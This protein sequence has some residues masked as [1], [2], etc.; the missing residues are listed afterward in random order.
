VSWVLIPIALIAIG[1]RQWRALQPTDRLLVSGLGA[2]LL[3]F[4][5]HGVVDYFME[6]T[7]TYGLF[8]LI[9]GLYSLSY[10]V[11]LIPI[12]INGFGLQELSVTYLF[13]HVGSLSAAWLARVLIR[14]FLCQSSGR[15][16][17]LCAAISG[18]KNSCTWTESH[19]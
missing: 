2:A 6:F 19:N 16:F 14:M 15:C 13:L 5:L 10:L 4:F 11:T 17:S 1:R 7:P 18:Q 12:S 8:W 3:A 9:A